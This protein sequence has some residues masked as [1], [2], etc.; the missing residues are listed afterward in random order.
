MDDKKVLLKFTCPWP[1]CGFKW[2]Q[3]VGRYDGAGKHN[4]G[5]SQVTCPMCGN[6]VTTWG[7]GKE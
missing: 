3:T 7:D 6:R 4:K 2:Q 5:S 1:K